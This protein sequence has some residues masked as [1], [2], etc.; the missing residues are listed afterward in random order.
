MTALLDGWRASPG[1]GPEALPDE[2]QIATI[3][4]VGVIRFTTAVAACGIAAHPGDSHVRGL[5]GVQIRPG[6]F[7]FR[8]YH[9]EAP[10]RLRVR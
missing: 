1:K 5:D 4:T 10:L 3:P 7:L 2:N 6:P 9:E 8:S